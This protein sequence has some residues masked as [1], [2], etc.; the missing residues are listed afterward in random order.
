MK[1]NRDKCKVLHLGWNNQGAH[2]RLGA[3]LL[4]GTFRQTGSWADSAMALLAE[5][6]GLPSSFSLCQVTPAELCPVLIHTVH[7]RQ[8]DWEM[9]QRRVTKIIKGLENL[10]CKE[11][12]KELHI[13]SLEKAQRDLI[14]VCQCLKPDY[15]EEGSSLFTRSHLEMTRGKSCK[16]H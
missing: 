16:L 9:V 8:A 1:F 13:F 3:A 11:T 6:R 10:L 4:K 12:L 15:R 2:C 5:V 7:K 14:T